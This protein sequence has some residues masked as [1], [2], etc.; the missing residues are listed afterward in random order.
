MSFENLG[1]APILVE[2]L[3]KMGFTRPTPIQ[4][5]AIPHVVKG[6]DLL[7]LAQTGTGKTAAFGLPMITRILAFGKRPAPKTVRALVLAPT[8]EL[9]SQIHENLAAF[10]EDAPVSIQRVVGGASLNKQEQALARGTDVLIATPGRLLDLL[11]RRALVLSETR[12]LVLDEAD[13]MLDIGFIHALRKIAK[14]I[15]EERQTLLFSATMPPLMEE[16]ARTYLS[17]PVRVEAAPP[18]KVADKIE[19]GVHFTTQKEKATLLA[20]YLG[21]H[22]G[23][24]AL[25]FSRTKHGADKLARL[26]ENWGFSVAAIHGNKSQNQRERA[27][28]AFRAGDLAVLVATDVAARGLDIPL[29]AH[30]YN[31]DLPNVPENYVHRIGR[32]AR[33]GRDGRAVALCGPME[34]GDLRAIEKA[35]GAKIPVIGG[36]P[37]E[38][39]EGMRPNA[40]NRASQQNRA[41]EKANVGKRKPKAPKP[42]T[43]GAAKPEAKPAAKKPVRRSQK[44]AG[45][46]AP[47]RRKG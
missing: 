11:D 42:A 38:D 32:T 6:R 24:H 30:V 20:E 13:Q 41:A 16:L 12:Y 43:T 40:R 18:G 8:R 5:K 17:D 33:A 25:V 27:L 37:H 47:P 3:T 2:N 23:E 46:S 45:G 4:T 35:M 36:T 1:L 19:Q 39:P 15:P 10:A 44:P 22:Q 7:G 21:S 34:M 29:V 26:L 31:Y 14:L 28:A 9:A